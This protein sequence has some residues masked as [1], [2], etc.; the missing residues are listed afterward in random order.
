MSSLGFAA[1]PRVSRLL[2]LG[3]LLFS[4]KYTLPKIPLNEKAHLARKIGKMQL[5][6]NEKKA[7]VRSHYLPRTYLKHF[8]LEDQL[9]MYMKGEKF[10]ADG[11]KAPDDRI[12]T[13]KGEE[14]LKNVGLKNNLYNPG[15]PEISSDD[16]EEIFQEYGENTYDENVAA[17]E[18]LPNGSLLPQEIKDS[19]APLI[20]AMR[21]RVPLFKQEIEQMDESFTKHMMSRQYEGM[22]TEDVAKH[23]KEITGKEISEEMAAKVAKSFVDKDYKMEY[24]RGYFIKYALLMLNDHVDILHQMTWQVCRSDRFFVTSDNPFVYFV[25]PQHTNFYVSPKSLVSQHSEAFFPLTKNMAV[26]LSWRKHPERV[27]AANREVVDGFN[28]NISRNS[29]D[30]IFSPMKMNSLKEFTEKHIPYP[31][32][33]RIS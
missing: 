15:I 11:S 28:F 29:L 19:L 22:S 14:G 1:I 12:L 5:M 27:E 4:C 24:P 21:V 32:G 13:V 3:R 17:L 31:F 33:F 6:S 9:F 2:G 30:Y 20:A 23:Y 18:A 7:T 25:P 8:L 16:L 10:F 26:H